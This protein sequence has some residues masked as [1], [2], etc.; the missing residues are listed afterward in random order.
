MHP[1]LNILLLGSAALQGV[2]G[3]AES[4]SQRRNNAVKRSVDDFL[5]T[6]STAALNKLLCNIG[7]DG[8]QSSGALGGVVIA[9]PSTQDPNCTYD[10]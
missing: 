2:L 3:R 10:I 6:E 7:A 8:C 4:A 5:S 9:S 1:F